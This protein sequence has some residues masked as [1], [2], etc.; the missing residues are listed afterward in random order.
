MHTGQ[1]TLPH[2]ARP[3]DRYVILST[4]QKKKVIRLESHTKQDRTGLWVA[5]RKLVNHT[6]GTRLATWHIKGGKPA[7]E[8]EKAAFSGS[9]TVRI[10]CLFALT[11][12]CLS[13]AFALR[14]SVANG[15]SHTS[16]TPPFVPLCLLQR[17]ASTLKE[18]STRRSLFCLVSLLDFISL[19]PN[20]V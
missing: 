18:S 12:R 7:K 6:S 14:C 2:A 15:T 4:G 3:K 5:G 11:L 9:A 20:S 10:H 13:R 16:L 1:R 8:A 17:C 19:G